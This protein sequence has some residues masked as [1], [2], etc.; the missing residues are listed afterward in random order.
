ME[1]KISGIYKFLTESVIS[2]LLS[3]L[4]MSVIASVSLYLV[5]VCASALLSGSCECIAESHTCK[6]QSDLES[7]YLL[8]MCMMCMCTH[9]YNVQCEF[10]HIFYRLVYTCTVF[11]YTGLRKQYSSWSDAAKSLISV[12][13]V[14][15]SSSSFYTHQHVVKQTYGFCFVIICS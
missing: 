5:I 6:V 7:L 8:L 4:I 10:D 12:Y 15:H 11:I 13:R 1:G 9:K 2:G 3:P 14:C